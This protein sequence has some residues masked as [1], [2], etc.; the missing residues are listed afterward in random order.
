MLIINENQEDVNVLHIIIGQE[1]DFQFNM[2]GQLIMDITEY[3]STFKEGK[4]CIVV[5]NQCKSE[6][7]LVQ[8]LQ[9]K[10][11]QYKAAAILE[12]YAEENLNNNTKKESKKEKTNEDKSNGNGLKCPKCHAPNS[13]IILNGEVYPCEICKKID[14]GI[15][16]GV[17]PP[18]PTPEELKKI[19]AETENENPQQKKSRARFIKKITEPKNNKEKCDGNNNDV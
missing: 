9:I 3:V 5:L 2:S 14:A 10:Q 12:Q 11:A 15:K 8:E 1:T 4:R 17:V 19:R 7:K 18:P 6:E 13:A 16:S